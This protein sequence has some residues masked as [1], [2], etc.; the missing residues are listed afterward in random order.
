MSADAQQRLDSTNRLRTRP[1]GDHRAGDAEVRLTGPQ[2][3]TRARGAQLGSLPERERTDASCTTVPT[4]STP[5]RMAAASQP[6]A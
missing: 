1:P 2:G 3:A 5:H 6:S 4:M